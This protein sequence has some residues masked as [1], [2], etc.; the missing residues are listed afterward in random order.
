MS[1]GILFK[2]LVLGINEM[3]LM[4]FLWCFKSL[5]LVYDLQDQYFYEIIKTYLMPMW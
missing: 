3:V 4:P 1:V 5:F 2:I